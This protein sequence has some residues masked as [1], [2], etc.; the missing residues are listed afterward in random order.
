MRTVLIRVEGAKRPIHKIQLEPG[1]RVS[2]I[3]Q[4]LD[5]PE[6]YVL[7]LA[8]EPT[9]S[10]PHEAEVHSL[11]CDADH[12]I[13]RPGTTRVENADAFILTLPS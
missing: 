12:L 7:A 5:V 13:V 6:G 2:D 4:H 10:F 3:L 9:N 11:V 8:T 1:T